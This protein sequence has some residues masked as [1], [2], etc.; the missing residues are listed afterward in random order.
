MDLF[1]LLA[2]LGALWGGAIIIAT[3]RYIRELEQ[4]KLL[5][6]ARYENLGISNP[7]D[8]AQKSLLN[9]WRKGEDDGHLSREE[10]KEVVGL[11]EKKVNKRGITN[12]HFPYS[13]LALRILRPPE[14]SQTEARTTC[15]WG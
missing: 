5:D 10:S 12:Q 11:C 14:D 13:N 1:P 9:L 6:E 7:T 15:S 3:K 2:I 4:D 8:A